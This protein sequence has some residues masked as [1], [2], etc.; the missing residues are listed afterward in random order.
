VVNENRK[1]SFSK[2]KVT[3]QQIISDFGQRSFE[4]TSES[5]G[6]FEWCLKDASSRKS[7]LKR[8]KGQ[9]EGSA[10]T[11]RSGKPG[12]ATGSRIQK[13]PVRITVI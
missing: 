6:T 10:V 2:I 12:V 9:P 1:R 4:T 13:Q 5:F 7:A 8:A 11:G 3:G